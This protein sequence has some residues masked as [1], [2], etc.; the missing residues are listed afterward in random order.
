MPARR[1]YQEVTIANNGT[2]S[3]VA[4]LGDRSVCAIVMPAAWTA[5]AIS[6]QAS[7]DNVTFTD[8]Y[9]ATTERSITPSATAS[10][11]LVVDPML[12]QFNYLKI[13]S[14][15]TGAT[16]AQGGERTIGIISRTFD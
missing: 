15:L 5:A 1:H 8:V 11:C 12:W 3:S 2:L 4:A 16:Q 7:P 10:R 14:G 13:R 9:D 6:F